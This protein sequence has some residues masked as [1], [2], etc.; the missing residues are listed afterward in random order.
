MVA[1]T[2]PLAGA[3]R[4]VGNLPFFARAGVH[5]ADDVVLTASGPGADLFHG[6]IDNTHVFRAMA[7]ALGL[8]A[9]TAQSRR[10]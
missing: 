2:A 7:R 9:E 6:R 10:E 1:D 4:K 8:G 5:S 3:A